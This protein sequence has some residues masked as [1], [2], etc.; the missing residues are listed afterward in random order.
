M[1]K[2]KNTAYNNKVLV[3]I[4]PTIKAI[5]SKN[6]IFNNGLTPEF[7]KFV[8]EKPYINNLIVSLEELHVALKDINTKHG[9]YYEYYKRAMQEGE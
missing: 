8:E 1:S 3:Y 6:K 4:G 5:V 7:E 9:F 2:K